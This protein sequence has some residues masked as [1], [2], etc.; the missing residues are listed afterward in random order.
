MP[1]LADSVRAIRLVGAGG[2]QY[3]IEPS[4]GITDSSLLQQFVEF[5]G[6]GINTEDII[7]D[8]NVFNAP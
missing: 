5:G 2:I 8:D 1:P 6:T 3:W 4:S 7:Y